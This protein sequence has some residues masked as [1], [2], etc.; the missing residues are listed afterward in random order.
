MDENCMCSYAHHILASLQPSACQGPSQHTALDC[1]CS[2]VSVL[3]F[4]RISSCLSRE[5][6][7]FLLIFP[8]L[9]ACLRASLCVLIINI[10]KL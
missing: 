3:G 7:S 8:M 5:S 9:K 2:S 6:N 10:L 4:G 1:D